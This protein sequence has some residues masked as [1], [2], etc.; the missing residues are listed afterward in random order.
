MFIRVKE[1]TC[2]FYHHSDEH[3]VMYYFLKLSNRS[4]RPN[5]FNFI[6][7]LINRLS[8]PTNSNLRFKP[9]SVLEVDKSLI[10]S[11]EQYYLFENDM[12]VMI[13]MIVI[14]HSFFH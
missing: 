5:Q 1:K 10:H 7:S 4:Q 11:I 13:E 6:Y 2:F 8:F 12:H 3:R 9:T 14:G